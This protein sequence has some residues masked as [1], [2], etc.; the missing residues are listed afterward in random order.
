MIL[1]RKTYHHETEM[2]TGNSFILGIGTVSRINKWG[3]RWPCQPA[4]CRKLTFTSPSTRRKRNNNEDH[5]NNDVDDVSAF[6][7]SPSHFHRQPAGIDQAQP[8]GEPLEPQELPPLPVLRE[9]KMFIPRFSPSP[10]QK[11]QRSYPP[12]SDNRLKASKTLSHELHLY[13]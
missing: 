12:A 7:L 8:K 2:S 6:Q 4:N 11:G 10:P 9:L 13:S 5:N 1:S 3:I